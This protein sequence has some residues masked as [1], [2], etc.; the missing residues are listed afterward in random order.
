MVLAEA[1]RVESLSAVQRRRADSR[2][3]L[4][5]ARSRRLAREEPDL[6]FWAGAAREQTLSVDK[7]KS[8]CKLRRLGDAAV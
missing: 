1:D 4:T 7:S 2:D 8:S 5:S 6:L 3:T